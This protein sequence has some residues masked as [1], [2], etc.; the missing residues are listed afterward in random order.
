[1]SFMFVPQD[2][3]RK[4]F[5]SDMIIYY[6][7]V[8][9]KVGNRMSILHHVAPILVSEASDIIAFFSASNIV[10]TFSCKNKQLRALAI[11]FTSKILQI[12]FALAT[13]GW[14]SDS[15]LWLQNAYDLIGFPSFT[16]ILMKYLISY[17]KLYISNSLFMPK[18]FPF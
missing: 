6:S 5:V 8:I 12:A 15:K 9:P 4:L 7:P 1:M 11:G 16:F 13:T 2:L 10:I 14:T 17:V 18:S 3:Y